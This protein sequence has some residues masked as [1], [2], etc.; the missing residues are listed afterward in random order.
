MLLKELDRLNMIIK[1]HSED[2]TESRVKYQKL[3]ESLNQFKQK[4]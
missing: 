3:E 4:A 2:M 1:N